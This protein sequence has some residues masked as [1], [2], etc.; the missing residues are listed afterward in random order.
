LR[1]ADDR[2]VTTFDMTTLRRTGHIPAPIEVRHLLPF[3]HPTWGATLAE[4]MPRDD[5]STIGIAVL[6][7]AILSRIEI[8]HI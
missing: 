2:S 4:G 6:G 3:I 7:I 8:P 5:F 1:C